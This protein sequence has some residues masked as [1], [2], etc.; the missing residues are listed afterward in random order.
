MPVAFEVSNALQGPLDVLVA[1]KIGAPGHSEYGI[2]AIAEVGGVVYDK[3][4]LATIVCVMT[5]S[6]FVAGASGTTCSTRR[7]TTMGLRKTGWPIPCPSC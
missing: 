6:P 3:A 5:P 1:R 2:G 4:V 7:P